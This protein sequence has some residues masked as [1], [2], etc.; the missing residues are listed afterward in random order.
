[1]LLGD[2]MPA[3]ANVVEG[4]AVVVC[5]QILPDGTLEVDEGYRSCYNLRL[6]MVG[7]SAK[8][9]VVAYSS[10]KSGITSNMAEAI[11]DFFTNAECPFLA[12]LQAAI[13]SS[14]QPAAAAPSQAGCV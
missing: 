6:K 7:F 10:C 1:M 11:I 5:L 8:L 3:S 9:P 4:T 12:D 14:T 2:N 13:R